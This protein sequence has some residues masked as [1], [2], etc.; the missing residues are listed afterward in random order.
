MKKLIALTLAGAL[1]FTPIMA[2][3]EEPDLE[4]RVAALEERVTA[5]EALLSGESSEEAPAA[6]APDEAAA[7]EE[8][9]ATSD[10]IFEY[11]GCS[12]QYVSSEVRQDYQGNNVLV[13][14]F[15]YTNNSGKDKAA[16]LEFNVQAFQNGKENTGIPVLYPDIQE[17]KDSM[18]QIMSGADPIRVAFAEPLSDTSDVI[19][20]VSPLISLSDEH[21]DI[22]IKL[23]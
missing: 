13:V 22:P 11:G 21:L 5:L 15:D 10:T 18:A 4:A 19:V 2:L 6:A 12:L 7:P 23:Q 9:P 20:R 14:Y 17:H 16:Y 8:A 1:A 3:A